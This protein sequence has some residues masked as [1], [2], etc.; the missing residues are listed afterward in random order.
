MLALNIHTNIYLSRRLDIGG[1]GGM[2]TWGVL[3]VR[4]TWVIRPAFGCMGTGDPGRHSRVR[5]G[6]GWMGRVTR[7]RT[8]SRGARG[9]V[10]SRCA[11]AAVSQVVRAVVFGGFIPAQLSPPPARVEPRAA[12]QVGQPPHQVGVLWPRSSNPPCTPIPAHARFSCTS[13]TASGEL[14]DP[15]ARHL[16]ATTHTV[17]VS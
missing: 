11:G 8:H 9:P 7:V 16:G 6:Q 1:P 10:R 3:W 17:T 5:R 12:A 4:L 14:G 13:V 2:A 15:S